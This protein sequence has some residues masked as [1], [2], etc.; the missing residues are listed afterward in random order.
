MDAG[1]LLISGGL[2]H[3]VEGGG[4]CIG[5]G[6]PASA[7]SLDTDIGRE[8]GSA[9][10]TRRLLAEHVEPVEPRLAIAVLDVFALA[11]SRVPTE[12]AASACLRAEEWAKPARETDDAANCRLRGTSVCRETREALGG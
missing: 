6:V 7:D 5:R 8:L 11:R 3:S 12:A 4:A 2:L 10:A 1:A 9:R